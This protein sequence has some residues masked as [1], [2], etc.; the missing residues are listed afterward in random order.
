MINIKN[1]IQ[2]SPATGNRHLLAGDVAAMMGRGGGAAA[3]RWQCVGGAMR[4]FIASIFV[5]FNF[6]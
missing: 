4:I 6:T 2:N 1:T 3:R 5:T